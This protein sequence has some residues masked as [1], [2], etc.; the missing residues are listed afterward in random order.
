VKLF[1][2][3]LVGY[4]SYQILLN[5]SEIQN[6][7]WL[8][9]QA[10]SQQSG[11]SWSTIDFLTRMLLSMGAILLLPRQFHVTVVEANSHEQMN[12][13]R[14]LLP[15]YL[16]LVS[17][18]V[19][20]IAISG[21]LFLPQD[22]NA[23][24]YVLNLPLARGQTAL[25]TL[26]FIGGLSA[27]TGMVIVAAISLSTMV[28]NDIVMPALISIKRLN[29]LQRHDLNRLI[30]TVRRIVILLI[31]LFSYGYYRLSDTSQGLAN[32]GLL[33]FAAI[34]Q[35]APAVIAGLYWQTANRLGAIAGLSLGFITWAYCL[36]LPNFIGSEQL[37]LIFASAPLIHP[38][39][40]LG[41][42]GLSNLSHGVFWS[43]G[44]NIGALI[45]GS[46][47]YA[48]SLLDRIQA[49]L[50]LHSTPEPHSISDN[51][52]G[53]SLA[54]IKDARTLCESII[55][56]QRTREIFSAEDVRVENTDE[57]LPVTRAL[58]QRIE[59]A[60]ASIIGAS[61]ARH[62]VAKTLLGE[63]FSAED[64]V[65]LM[66][67]TSQAISFNQELL[68]AGFENISQGISV[69]DKNQR[70]VA[71]NSRYAEIFEYPQDFLYI[72]MPVS[73]LIRFN[74]ERG[75]CGP[76]TINQHVA[77]RLAHMRNGNSH[78]HESW[79][80]SGRYIKS[81]GNPMPGGGFV[82]SYTDLTEQ[83]ITEVA[84][85]DSEQNIRFYTDHLPLMVCYVDR[86]KR[87]QFS[88]HAYNV[89]LKMERSDIIGQ[90]FTGVYKDELTGSRS[91]HLASALNGKTVRFTINFTDASQQVI[92]YLVNY[93]PQ[94]ES[95]GNV[96]GFFC[97][98]QDITQSV[99]AEKLLRK[100]NEELEKRVT[101]RTK[102][103]EQL[104]NKLQ[105]VTEGK[106][107]FL[108]AAS[109]DLLQPINAARLFNQSVLDF[110]TS[111][112]DEVRSL[113]G[114][115]DRSL[116]SADKLLRALLD[117][118]KLDAGSLTPDL[119]HFDIFELLEELELEMVQIAKLKNI[120]LSVYKRHLGVR[121]DR[122][123]LRSMIQNF[124]SNA[125][126][127]TE[128]GRVIVGC[129]KRGN[130]VEIQVFDS[131]IGI[132]EGD[133]KLIF[134]EFHRI[135]ED[136]GEVDEKGLGLGL[137][138]THRLSQILHH[139]IDVKSEYGKGSC[140]SVTLPLHEGEIIRY[141]VQSNWSPAGQLDQLRVLCLEN[142]Y[143]VLEATVILLSK[144]GCKVS[145]CRTASEAEQLLGQQ[146]FDAVLADFSLN[147]K[148]NGL[149]V[150]KRA[151]GEN[152][153]W[154]GVMISAEQDPAIRKQARESG[155]YFLP[156]PVD[157]SSL[158]ALLR[159]ARANR[160]ELDQ[161][162]SE[163]GKDSKE[164]FPVDSGFVR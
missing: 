53:A 120:E 79:R 67:Q 14:W 22:S 156:K 114:K 66:D 52:A 91:D 126:R 102:D 47:R 21:N 45:F 32:I 50:F 163:T 159:R 107:H 27:A 149:D 116:V 95:D 145:A 33:S 85:R 119:S 87:V 69:I 136:H 12:V 141:P 118:S 46:L 71:W 16:L 109:H 11:S 36:M 153:S 155:F 92:H 55:G 127:Y 9:L 98:Y 147:G 121:S 135:N 100:V 162:E 160:I 34:I 23:D 88:N 128:N 41:I 49:S 152:R 78:N 122:R 132:R 123:L 25:A 86:E 82:T 80:Q 48:P 150:L 140:F 18:V 15:I 117:I 20:P 154:I 130:D 144:W 30:L 24:L 99:A 61:S 60:I 125:I 39:H 157:P 17:L 8:N 1:V 103:L 137:A 151:S 74:A 35:F 81:Q 29:I 38:Q 96:S 19:L 110:N 89:S 84:L 139:P 26:A 13:A 76:G 148:V 161:I 42:D 44:L 63:D 158:R 93:I 129:R 58:V 2:I 106:T 111:D 97:Y 28:C 70:L 64:M 104:N 77:K 7:S 146:Q 90:P 143:E 124:I 68:E 112:N 10:P 65:V 57:T 43:L 62:V 134:R 115:V 131:G 5:N 3:L 94:L 83:K 73:E 133:L 72:G 40:L 164:D 56:E 54:S 37:D 142:D 113:A 4:F 75:E 59:K 51:V 105:H 31:M 6:V 101:D 108:A 138:I